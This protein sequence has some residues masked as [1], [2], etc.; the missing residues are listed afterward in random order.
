MKSSPF[1]KPC[2]GIENCISCKNNPWDSELWTSKILLKMFSFQF[3]NFKNRG[4]K[5]ANI[6]FLCMCFTH[7]YNFVK[8]LK[9]L[10]KQ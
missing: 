8:W 3:E 1:T 9:K 10:G 6:S 5:G 2:K 4:K 7:K